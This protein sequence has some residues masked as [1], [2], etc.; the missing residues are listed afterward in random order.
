MK[1][2]FL[3]SIRA[4][5][6]KRKFL[7]VGQLNNGF[8][9]QNYPGQILVSYYEASLVADYIESRWG[10]PAIRKMLLLYRDGKGTPD[11][12]KEGL[13]VTLG[14]FDTEF[15]KWVD[16]KAAGISTEKYR[17]SF[18]AGV[19]ALEAGDADTAIKTLSEAVNMY[20]E[21]SD[22]DNA[23]EPLI[24]AY[25]KKG[26]KP[27]AIATLKKFLNYS[28]TSYSSYTL[29]STLLE[30]SGDLAGAAK[31]LEGAMY[32]RPMDLAGHEKLGSLTL[33]LKQYKDAERE[34]KALLALNTTDRA[35][36]YYHLAEANFGQGNKADAYKNVMES[37][38]IAP[39]YQPAQSLLLQVR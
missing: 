16:A 20:P 7:P 30:E 32:V 23:Y 11:V 10:F 1:L 6:P 2:Q 37:L 24:Q 9:H 18:E 14:E 13:N 31:S 12:F 29:L 33:K 4:N 34:Y 28:E 27:N 15:M 8:I 26:D 36:A 5:D 21:F 19:K 38:K 25:L 3:Q 39:T 22:D 17:T 35:G